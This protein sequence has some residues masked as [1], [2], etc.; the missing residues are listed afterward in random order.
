MGWSFV[1]FFAY[2]YPI[3]HQLLSIRLFFSTESPLYLYQKSICL[4]I[5]VCFPG[6]GFVLFW[7]VFPHSLLVFWTV[8]K[9]ERDCHMTSFTK[10][11]RLQF[12]RR[13]H[14]NRLPRIT[15]IAFS[16]GDSRQTSSVF[17]FPKRSR[18]SHLFLW[19]DDRI[20]TKHLSPPSSPKQ[21]LP[22]FLLKGLT[23]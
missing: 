9:T 7:L 19:C 22:S 16:F 5:P 11:V 2:G 10:N 21:A 18:A 4:C 8:L 1:L 17:R 20:S 14:H 6:A 23:M 12:Q 13:T 3:F 15:P